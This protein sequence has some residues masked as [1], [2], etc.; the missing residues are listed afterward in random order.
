MLPEIDMSFIA[1]QQPAQIEDAHRW[2]F[3]SFSTHC[4]LALIPTINDVHRHFPYLSGW[5]LGWR[6]DL[7]CFLKRIHVNLRSSNGIKAYNLQDFRWFIRSTFGQI[8]PEI[9]SLVAR[10]V[11]FPILDGN[12]VK[13]H[14]FYGLRCQ[15]YADNTEPYSMRQ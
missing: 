6:S 14:A 5:L 12:V 9:R 3:R 15:E 10:D 2:V 13:S 11:S 8:C 7:C 4:A 1:G